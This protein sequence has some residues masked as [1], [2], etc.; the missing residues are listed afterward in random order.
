MRS[1]GNRARRMI[2]GGSSIRG[3]SRAMQSRTFCSVFIFMYLHSL[4]RQLS[5]GSFNHIEHGAQMNSLP[6]HSFCI[7]WIIPDSVTI[8]NRFGWARLAMSNH[9]FGRANGISQLADL[10]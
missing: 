2:S 6:G 3:A 1:I 5:E 7:R 8:T 10:L 9:L 4:Q